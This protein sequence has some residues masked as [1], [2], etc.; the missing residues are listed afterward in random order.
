VH[1]D[2]AMRWLSAQDRSSELGR[3]LMEVPPQP[4]VARR[5]GA[6]ATILA[7][8]HNSTEGQERVHPNSGKRRSWAS[9]LVQQWQCPSVGT[10]VT[11]R[12]KRM[13]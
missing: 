6:L 8:D 5:L 9:R 1:H 7:A 4:G 11:L 10:P 12:T 3:V 13:T 2:A